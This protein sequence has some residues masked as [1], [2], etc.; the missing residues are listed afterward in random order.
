MSVLDLT[1]ELIRRPSLTPDDAGCQQLIADRLVRAGFQLEHLPFGEVQNL[2]ATHGSGAPLLCFAGHTDVVPPGPLSAWTSPPFEP[3]V[4]EGKL[5]GR[6]A[7][8]MKASV[9]AMTIAAER[10]AKGGHGGTIAVLLTSDEE[11]P[12]VD[13]TRL[14]IASLIARGVVIDGALVGEPTSEDAFGDVVKSGRR[15]SMTGVL[16]ISGVQ[17]HTAYPDKARNAVHQAIPILAKLLQID[18]GLPAEGFPNTTLQITNVKAGTGANNVVPGTCE[19]EFNIRFGPSL[20]PSHI[21]TLVEANVGSVGWSVSALPFATEPGRLLQDLL[22]AIRSETG[23]DSL[24]SNG[25]GTS[26]ARFFAR[27]GIPVAEFGPLNNSIHA[28]DE[29]VEVACLEPLARVYE[30]FARAFLTDANI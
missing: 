9:A 15:G 2:W 13:G 5:F 17:G 1:L 29:N 3:E 11:G 28:I 22:E 21:Q 25:G 16:T 26:D 20:E 27:H 24:R 19:V 7:S 4:R 14:A 30:K 8:D 18:W 10:L 12:G 23:V 6:G